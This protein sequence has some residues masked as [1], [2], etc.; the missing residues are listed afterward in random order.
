MDITGDLGISYLGISRSATLAEASS[1]N[2]CN[3]RCGQRRY[4]QLCDSIVAVPTPEDTTSPDRV[5]WRHDHEVFKPT[6][7]DVQ[8]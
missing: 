8:T 1:N 6:F 3:I 5:L 7:S 2:G 4:P